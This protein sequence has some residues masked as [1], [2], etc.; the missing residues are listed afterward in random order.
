MWKAINDAKVKAFLVSREQYMSD[1]SYNIILPRQMSFFKP[2]SL[3]DALSSPE[4][5]L[6]QAVTYV[7]VCSVL[8]QTT[9]E[10]S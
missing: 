6:Q 2:R 1:N 4:A 5:L 8:Q 9:T 10:N 7:A 3:K